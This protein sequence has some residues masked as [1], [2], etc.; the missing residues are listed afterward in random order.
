MLK[1]CSYGTVHVLATTKQLLPYR[2]APNY[3]SFKPNKQTKTTCAYHPN[4]TANIKYFHPLARMLLFWITS[5]DTR[6]N[7]NERAWPSPR[8]KYVL[9]E[10][11]AT[12]CCSHLSLLWPVGKK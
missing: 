8:M 6:N 1:A 5:T 4:P 9:M 7:L 10:I 11:Q 3:K 12:S 2:I